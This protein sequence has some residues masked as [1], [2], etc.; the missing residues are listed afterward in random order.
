MDELE[1]KIEE[2]KNLKQKNSNEKVLL[3]FVTDAYNRVG[4]GKKFA[5]KKVEKTVRFNLF[6]NHNL[7]H[8]IKTNL[9]T[10]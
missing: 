9:V 4:D 6:H 10:E 3:S 8:L 5:F 7:R 2:T 1:K